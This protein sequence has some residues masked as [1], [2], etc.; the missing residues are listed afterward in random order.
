MC[1]PVPPQRNLSGG[2]IKRLTG[3]EDAHIIGE[4][5]ALPGYEGNLPTLEIFSYVNSSGNSPNEING[6]GLAHLAFEVDNIAGFLQKII[7][8]GGKQLGEVV[9]S[10]YPN[11]IIG[12]FV[13]TKDIEGN[14]IE[15][16]N[17][18]EKTK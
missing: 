17:W 2:W 5:L 9:S 16:Q 10:E 18:K 7:N 13:Y 11:G 3:I 8:E 12:T 15:L 14:I 6:I 4:H 1:K